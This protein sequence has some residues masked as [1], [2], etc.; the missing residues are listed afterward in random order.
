MGHENVDLDLFKGTYADF[1]KWANA[2][3]P[4]P[5]TPP[6]VQPQPAPVQPP[7]PQP[8][9]PT[10]QPVTPPVLGNFIKYTVK[11]D[12][13]LGGIS[14]K[15]HTTVD[16]IMA[17]NPQITNRNIIGLGWVLKIPAA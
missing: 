12:D 9:P 14:L 13:T 11:K 10:P 1:L 17:A 2:K 6:P 15:Y 3:A 5:V 16:A 8:Q 4:T 7:T